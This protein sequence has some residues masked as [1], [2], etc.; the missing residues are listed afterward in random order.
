MSQQNGHKLRCSPETRSK[1]EQDVAEI[2]V[3][4]GAL[5]TKADLSE[6][7][8]HIDERLDEILKAVAW[9]K[10]LARG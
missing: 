5:A 8:E 7:R 9:K 2:R 3:M 4:L 10:R 6:L 1:I